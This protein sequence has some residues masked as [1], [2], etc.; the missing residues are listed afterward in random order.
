[1]EIEKRQ[2]AGVRRKACASRGGFFSDGPRIRKASSDAVVDEDIHPRGCRAYLARWRR[3]KPLAARRGIPERARA[4]WKE[5]KVVASPRLD[6]ARSSTRRQRGRATRALRNVH[7][8]VRERGVRLDRGERDG[9]GF[10]RHLDGGDLGDPLLSLA[11]D[12]SLPRELRARVRAASRELADAG[13]ATLAATALETYGGAAEV[14][15]GDPTRPTPRYRNTHH[16]PS[17]PPSPTPQAARHL[18]AVRAA[19]T[20]ACG[21][22][23]GTWDDAD[24]RPESEPEPGAVVSRPASP[25]AADLPLPKTVSRLARNLA[26]LFS[27]LAEEHDARLSRAPGVTPDHLSS[28]AD[29]LR[30]SDV[31]LGRFFDAKA[32]VRLVFVF[33]PGGANVTRSVVSR[34]AI[35]LPFDALVR[36]ARVRGTC[37]RSNGAASLIA[38]AISNGAEREPSLGSSSTSAARETRAR[39]R[40]NPV[41]ARVPAEYSTEYS[42]NETPRR[43]RS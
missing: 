1:M 39:P 43:R 4:R 11:R 13:L 36:A 25:A 17:P 15:R 37:A 27:W 30:E 40:R 31:V 33:P 38:S 35:A 8:G 21:S 3:W 2:A 23:R 10:E 12:P 22:E 26:K 19:V 18:A 42:T 14:R 20:T 16:S 34:G 41:A 24:D 6:H 28:L 32:R 9:G 29:H 5:V 7:D